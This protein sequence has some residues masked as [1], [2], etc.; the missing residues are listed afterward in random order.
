VREASGVERVK[1][2]GDR[3]KNGDNFTNPQDVSCSQEFGQ[4]TFRTFGDDDDATA[5]VCADVECILQ[6]RR[7]DAE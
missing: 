7:G 5:A 4:G 1:R 6:V 2:R 3:R